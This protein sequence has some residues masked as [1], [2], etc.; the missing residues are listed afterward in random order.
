MHRFV[1]AEDPAYW[2]VP[3]K[4]NV[5]G[6]YHNLCM[7]QEP[8]SFDGAVDYYV[9]KTP[10]YAFVGDTSHKTVSKVFKA[11]TEYAQSHFNDN[12]VTAKVGGGS[13]GIATA[14]NENIG[15]WLVL[16]TL[17]SAF[18]SFIVILI[19]IRSAVGGLL[20]LLPLF[21][22]T[23]IW[24]FIVNILGIEINSNTTAGMAI[25][26]GVGIDAEIYFLYRFREEFARINNFREALI[27]GFTKIRKGLI[28][29]HFALII[30]LW[31]LIPIPLYIGYVGF[32]MGLIV[33]ICFLISFTL[34][35]II[36]SVLQPKFLF[37]KK[38]DKNRLVSTAGTAR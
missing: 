11:A 25:A 15:K 16:S 26:M 23:I 35:P 3:D 8:G 38:G 6:F 37:N 10:L 36:W 34:S 31:I 19:L 9:Q 21:V 14:F 28:F 12:K 32:S 24:L 1:N 5:V 7:S 4:Q 29:S 30:G 18:A 2:V 17:L 20:L 27:L 13:I 22:G 33:L